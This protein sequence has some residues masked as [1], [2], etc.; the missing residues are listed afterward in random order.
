MLN[1]VFKYILFLIFLIFFQIVVFPKIYLTEY[2]TPFFYSAIILTLPVF[3][4]RYYVLLISFL[5]GWIMD[6]FYHTGGI[7]IASLV[8][9]GYLRYYWLKIIEPSERYEENQIPVMREMGRDWFLKYIIPMIFIHQFLLFTLEVFNFKYIGNILIRSILST[10]VST[11][12]AYIF[13][14]IFFRPERK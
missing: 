2:I 7:H 9:I 10:L 5:V 4:N 8:V 3:L 14:L 1:L 12:L 6:I 11:A 13:H